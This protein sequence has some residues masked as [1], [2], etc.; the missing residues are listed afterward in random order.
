M[1]GARFVTRYP[2]HP[3][4][5]Q[6]N[7]EHS[8]HASFV[9][10]RVLQPHSVDTCLVDMRTL[11]IIHTLAKVSFA[12]NESVTSLKLMD[13]GLAR[14][15]LSL[16]AALD[17]PFQLIGGALAARWCTPERPLRPWAWAFA[18]R[19]IFVGVMSGVVWL[20]PKEGVNGWFYI[21]LVVLWVLQSFTGY[22]NLLLS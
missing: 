17:F 9:Y 5:L 13:A 19:I 15:D 12:A 20:F 21:L 8:A 22:E 14:E 4:Y 2:L 7:L 16:L 6:N 3:A 18:P 11:M 10:S 1:S